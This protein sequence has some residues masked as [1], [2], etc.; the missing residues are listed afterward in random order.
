MASSDLDQKRTRL[1]SIMEEGDVDAQMVILSDQAAN[2]NVRRVKNALDIKAK[3]PVMF[4]L[5]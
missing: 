5:F 2:L 3:L 4:H 1:K